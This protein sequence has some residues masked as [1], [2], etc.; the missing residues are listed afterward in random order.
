MRPATVLVEALIAIEQRLPVDF[1]MGLARAVFQGVRQH[2]DQFNRGACRR[3]RVRRRGS[4]ADQIS[5]KQI[6][7]SFSLSGAINRKV[8]TVDGD[9]VGHTAGVGQPDQ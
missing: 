2:L 4:T 9:D 5:A 6:F 3:T 7:E 8:S 1:P